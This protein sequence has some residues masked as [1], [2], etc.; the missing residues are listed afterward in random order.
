M[1]FYTT[2]LLVQLK[3]K[4]GGLFENAISKNTELNLWNSVI[5]H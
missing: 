3:V 4:N 1:A 2:S 5:K